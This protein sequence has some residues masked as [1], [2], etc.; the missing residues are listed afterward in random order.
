MSI[1]TL[2]PSLEAEVEKE[3]ADVQELAA[4]FPAYAVLI[5]TA[6]GA[7]EVGRFVAVDLLARLAEV[8]DAS[9]EKQLLL[10]TARLHAWER[11]TR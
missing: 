9:P 3:V 1:P 6:S 11:I 7:A 4:D 5:Q 10:L 8:A 2:H